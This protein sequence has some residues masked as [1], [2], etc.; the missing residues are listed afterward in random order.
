MK[1]TVR[2]PNFTMTRGK[3]PGG[4]GSGS[5]KRGL[6]RTFKQV[7]LWGGLGFL[8]FV[9]FAWISLPT[10]ALAW[11]ISHEAKARGYIVDVGDL[12]VSPFGGVTLEQVQWTFAPSRPGQV[13][14]IFVIDEVDVDISILSLLVG[15]I[16]VDLEADLGDPEDETDGRL[17]ANFTKGDSESSFTLTLEDLPLYGVPKAAQALNAPLRGILALDIDLTMPEHKFAEATGSIDLSCS[18]CTVGDGEEKLYVPGYKALKSGVVVPEIDMGTL[19]GHMTVEDGVATS[20]GPIETRSDDVWVQISGSITFKDPFAKSRFDMVLKFNLSEKLQD[21]SEPM[22]FMIQTAT[23]KTKLDAPEK[24]LGFKLD[25]PVTKPRFIGIKSASRR[26]SRADKR[27]KQRARDE[28]RRKKRPSKSTSRRPGSSDTPDAADGP[29]PKIGEPLDVKPL[30]PGETG[31]PPGVP[32]PTDPPAG[33]EPTEEPTP[34]PEAEQ[35]VEGG[36]GE[37][38]DEGGDT[39]QP[40]AEDE[41]PTEEPVAD[42]GSA[43]EEGGAANAEEQGQDPAP[44]EGGDGN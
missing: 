27:A 25:G 23:A 14:T 29:K 6:W 1:L 8:F 2:L 12:S 38:G 10:R 21:E 9:I 5:S 32:T 18:S 36:G 11:R 40:A 7:L 34:E 37:G 39:P 22:R 44:E 43:P 13:P 33:R 42:D 24:G 26:Q 35:P 16:D 17:E 15:N 19:S 28:N 3:V 30:G 4:G 41:T 31:E 20:D